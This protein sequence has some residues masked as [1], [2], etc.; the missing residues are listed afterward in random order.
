MI[1]KQIRLLKGKKKREV[2]GLLNLVIEKCQRRNEKK[3]WV[4]D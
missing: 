4:H 1:K 3:E 2:W